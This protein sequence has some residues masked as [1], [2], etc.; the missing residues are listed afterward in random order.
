MIVIDFS[1]SVTG[2]T[3]RTIDFALDFVDPI[4]VSTGDFVR[5]SINVTIYDNSTY[6]F[7][8]E[9]GKQIDP[10]SQILLQSIPAQNT[11]S[12]TL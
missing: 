11:L 9:T 2:V 3:N 10:N 6:L 4:L 7:V 1:W 8:T 12:K 5:H